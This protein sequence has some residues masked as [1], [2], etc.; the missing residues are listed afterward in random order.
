MQKNGFII[1]QDFCLVLFQFWLM[2]ALEK[3]DIKAHFHILFLKRF[4]AYKVYIACTKTSY[5]IVPLNN[6]NKCVKLTVVQWK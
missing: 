4:I 3:H 6:F 5:K 2:L 1:N